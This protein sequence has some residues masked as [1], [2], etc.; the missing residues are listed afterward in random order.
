MNY[1]YKLIKKLLLSIIMLVTIQKSY[2]SQVT[3]A[4][5]RYL[6]ERCIAIIPMISRDTDT[7]AFKY[8]IYYI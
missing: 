3:F 5:S 7:F 1:L 6:I 2:I 8:R 4:R